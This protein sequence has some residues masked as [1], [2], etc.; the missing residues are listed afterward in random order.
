MPITPIKYKRR[1]EPE[2]VYDDDANDEREQ[3]ITIVEETI[4]HFDYEDLCAKI[5]VRLKELLNLQY[6]PLFDLCCDYTLLHTD[7]QFGGERKWSD[8]FT[9]DN[10]DSIDWYLQE[11]V[12]TTCFTAIYYTFRESNEDSSFD[13]VNTSNSSGSAEALGFALKKLENVL[14]RLDI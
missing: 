14:D 11:D 5:K 10:Y 2:Y 1:V 8:H 13:D 3:V 9:K 7:H 6:E 4:E 12:E